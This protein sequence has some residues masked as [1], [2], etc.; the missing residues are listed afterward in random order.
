[1]I[2]HIILQSVNL[3]SCEHNMIDSQIHSSIRDISHVSI[4]ALT[5]ATLSLRWDLPVAWVTVPAGG[6]HGAQVE[7]GLWPVAGGNR[8]HGEL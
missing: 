3:Q 7:L 2:L 5:H 8:F 6:A 1:M 4:Y